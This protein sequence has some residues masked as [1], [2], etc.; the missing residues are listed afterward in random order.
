M[1]EIIESIFKIKNSKSYVD[2]NKY[3]SGNIFGIT[4]TSRWE[5]MHSNFISWM[6]S[7]DA[8]HNLHFFPIYEF[9][10]SIK[11]VTSKPENSKSRGL[12]EDLM[13]KFFDDKFIVDA[14]V[15]REIAVEINE[16]TKTGSNKKKKIDILIQIQTKEKTLPIIIENKV[17]SN[18]N[19]PESNQTVIY[20]N[21]AEKTFADRSIYFEP[22]Y[23]FLLPDKS[24]VIPKQREYIRMTY[25]ELIDYVIDPSMFMCNDFTSKNNFRNY[26]QSLSYQTDNEK[27]DYAMGISAEERKILDEFVEKNERLLRIVLE[28]YFEDSDKA[29]K[30]S[31]TS[32]DMSKFQFNGKT[33]KTKSGLVLD[34]V[35]KY[36]EDYA[37]ATFE[38]LEKVFPK[39]LQ[40][41]YGVVRRYDSVPDKHKGIG[42]KD[43][44]RYFIGVGQ[45][46]KLPGETKDI[47]VCNQWSIDTI[48]V[49]ADHVNALNLG[50]II[51][52]ID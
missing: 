1:S 49:F 3:H 50:Y 16:K 24:G 18:E 42:T 38:D 29:A 32:H 39:N 22:I 37:P 44:P 40:G 43:I 14:T 7:P 12:A 35:Q 31:K 33:A 20:Y 4:K 30:L 46:I 28:E 27:G 13:L 48:T 21:W 23:I 25:Q 10:K 52:K 8:S 36:V 19:G 45:T 41:S 15:G 47:L 5:L 9:V 34:V 26:L 51:T 17:D 2:Y 6:L 11:L